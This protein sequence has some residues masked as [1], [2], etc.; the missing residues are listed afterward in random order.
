VQAQET[1]ADYENT[2]VQFRNLVKELQPAGQSK[3]GKE[4]A[5]T[6]EH[7]P[8]AESQAMINL[9][10]ELQ[11]TTMKAQSKGIFLFMEPLSLRFE[12]TNT[13]I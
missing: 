1:V 5:S 4:S 13:F 10:F 2:I 7:K 3:S 12:S 11:N 6:E 9:K 8:E